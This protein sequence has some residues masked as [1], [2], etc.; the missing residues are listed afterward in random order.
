MTASFVSLAALVVMLVFG[1]NAPFAGS[2]DLAAAWLF[3]NAFHLPYMGFLQG[4]LPTAIGIQAGCIFLLGGLLV[5]A[6]RW[7]SV[8]QT[9]LAVTLIALGPL[10]FIL[11]LGVFMSDFWSFILGSA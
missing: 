6:S 7:P 5:W 3:P 9:A 2:V 4:S 10:G 1:R 11:S 8:R